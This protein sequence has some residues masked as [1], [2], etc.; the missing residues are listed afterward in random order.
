MVQTLARI[1]RVVSLG[2]WA[3]GAAMTFI[4]A[5]YVFSIE[6][7]RTMAGNIMAPILH[8]GGWLHVA[9]AFIALAAALVVWPRRETAGRLFAKASFAALLGATLLALIMALWLEPHLVDLRT[10]IG[11]FTEATKDLPQRVEFRQLHG[12][13]MGLA[14]LETILAAVA[15]VLIA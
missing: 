2:L 13:S 14:L 11:V 1:L 9:L 7:D 8:V 6:T 10:Q 3:G 5:H 12:L 15:L 4:A